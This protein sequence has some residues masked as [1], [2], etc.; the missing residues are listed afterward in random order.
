MQGVGAALQ[1]RRDGPGEIGV[2][3]AI[4]EIAGVEL[5]GGVILRRVAPAHF[6]AGPAGADH[7]AVGKVDEVAVA[8]LRAG[9]SDDLG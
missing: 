8:G 7:G 6:L 4:V 9:V 2:P 3:A 5:D 1:V